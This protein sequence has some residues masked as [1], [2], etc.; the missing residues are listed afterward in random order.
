MLVHCIV[1]DDST[2]IIPIYSVGLMQAQP[3]IWSRRWK[4]EEDGERE[5]SARRREKEKKKW[6]SFFHL[7][8]KIYHLKE[9]SLHILSRHCY[10]GTIPA[11]ISYNKTCLLQELE[12]C[13]LRDTFLQTE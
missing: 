1:I 9:L 6:L 10:A 7:P 4:L 2:S 8:K 11:A 12:E 3:D 13:G 5:G